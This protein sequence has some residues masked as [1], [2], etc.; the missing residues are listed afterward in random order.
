MPANNDLLTAE[1]VPDNW[2]V[3]LIKNGEAYDITQLENWS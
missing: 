3:I 2:K 1:L